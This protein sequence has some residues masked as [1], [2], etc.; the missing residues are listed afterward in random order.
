MS[1]RTTASIQY[2]RARTKSTP[3]CRAEKYGTRCS[4]LV[5]PDG[6]PQF[7]SDH[8]EQYRASYKRYKVASEFAEAFREGVVIWEDKGKITELGNLAEVRDAIDLTE[9]YIEHAEEELRGRE[10]HTMIFFAYDPPDAGHV[11]RTTHVERQISSAYRILDRLRDRLLDL[12]PP[13]PRVRKS[14]KQRRRQKEKALSG[15]SCCAVSFDFGYVEEDEESPLES[16]MDE[17]ELLA[18]LRTEREADEMLRWYAERGYREEDERGDD[19]GEEDS[20]GPFV[21][22]LV[23]SLLR[24]G[25]ADRI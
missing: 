21:S 4:E 25:L 22:F 13:E 14:R 3:Q 20:M 12:T 19:E 18:D 1:S 15:I 9:T 23:A 2:R 24:L 17:E 8:A 6:G 5:H 10:L 7:C 16:G 11:K